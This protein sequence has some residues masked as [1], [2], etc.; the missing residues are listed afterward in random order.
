MKKYFNLIAVVVMVFAITL[1]T[2]CGDKRTELKFEGE[3]GTIV[4][5]VKEKAGYKISTKSEDFRTGREQAVLIGEGFKI[6]IEF[7][8]D[9]S[10]FYDSD[11]SMLKDSRK[12][13]DEFKDVTYSNIKGFQYFYDS[14][15]R[16]NVILPCG[17]SKDYVLVLYVYGSEDKEE[18]AKKAIK[19]EELLDVLNNITTIKA[20]K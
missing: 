15:N 13:Y 1:L 11:F 8:S 19:N 10:Y 3:E 14:Y 6:G 9:F 16:Y 5:N 2:G 7:D 4:F 18:S 12:S 17:D 20:A